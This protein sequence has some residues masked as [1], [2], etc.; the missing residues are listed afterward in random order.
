MGTHVP[1]GSN[2][3]ATAPAGH[4]P[5]QSGRVLPGSHVPSP[6]S[7][8]RPDPPSPPKRARSWRSPSGHRE[9]SW[10]ET[11]PQGRQDLGGTG[12][13]HPQGHKGEGLGDTVSDRQDQGRQP[14]RGRVC[15]P[16]EI[17]ESPRPAPLNTRRG[18]D[19]TFHTSPFCCVDQ[20]EVPGVGQ[21][22]HLATD[23]ALSLKT[24]FLIPVNKD[25]SKVDPGDVDES[26]TCRPGWRF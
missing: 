13:R 1:R 8:Q 24:K 20:E 11:W 18:S 6:P 4:L 23:F 16:L 22:G 12:A 26:V 7:W 5:P 15:T 17:C 25:V 21:P 10:G 14:R 2:P 9:Q 3:A 19:L